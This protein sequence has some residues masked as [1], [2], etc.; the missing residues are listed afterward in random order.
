MTIITTRIYVAADGTISGRAPAGVPAG[1]HEAEI[2]LHTTVP[3]AP[4]QADA[5][6]AIHAL[7]DELASL[8]I[9]DPRAPDEIIG[10]D[11]H[12]LFR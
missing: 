2:V 7:Q 6:T 8:P 5:L 9:L 12:G 10:Y 11:E 3:D 4:N 1:Q